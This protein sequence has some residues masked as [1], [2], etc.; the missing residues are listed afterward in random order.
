MATIIE[1]L[2]PSWKYFKNYFKHTR[3]E[4]GVEDLILK[5]KIE[6]S[7]K[8]HKK[9]RNPPLIALRENML[10]QVMKSHNNNNNNNN[11][12]FLWRTKELQRNLITNVLSST[13]LDTKSKIT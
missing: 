9:R 11:K 7:T 4:M 8:L 5:L 1:K 13:R 2:S 12:A 3:K 6:E 10:G